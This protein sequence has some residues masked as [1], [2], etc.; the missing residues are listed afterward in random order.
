MLGGL[1]ITPTA[2]PPLPPY[3]KTCLEAARNGHVALLHWASERGCPFDEKT[4]LEA[5]RNGHFA[6]LRSAR[7]AGCPWDAKACFEAAKPHFAML[8]WIAA[9]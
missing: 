3:A 8:K 1:T 6:A 4:C 2:P 5:A 7:E 9:Q